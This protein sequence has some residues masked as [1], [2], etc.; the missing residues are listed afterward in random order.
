MIRSSSSSI[1]TL[2]IP[3][4]VLMVLRNYTEFP[5]WTGIGSGG[6]YKYLKILLE[7]FQEGIPRLSHSDWKSIF[8]YICFCTLSK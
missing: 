1:N 2:R 6:F 8:S 7:R 4:P 5:N 3:V